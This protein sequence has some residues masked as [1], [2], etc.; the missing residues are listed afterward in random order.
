MTCGNKISMA[1]LHLACDRMCNVA[2]VSKLL[3]VKSYILHLCSITILYVLLPATAVV[4]KNALSQSATCDFSFT[5]INVVKSTAAL[6]LLN[7][8]ERIIFEDPFSL[9]L[10]NLSLNLSVL[11]L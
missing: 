4:Y 3:Y 8:E 5:V 9:N 2:N 6:P 1:L 7:E 11:W 10:S